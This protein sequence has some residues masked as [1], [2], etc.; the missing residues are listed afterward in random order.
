MKKRT[1]P[2]APGRFFDLGGRRMHAVIA[3]ELTGKPPI[4]LEAGLTG[5]SSCW[6]WAQEELARQTRV[7]SYDRAG[8]G[9]SSSCDAPRNAENIVSDLRRLLDVAEIQPPFVF[10]GHSLGGIFGRAYASIFPGEISAMALIDATHPE[11]MERS[12]QIR[13]SMRR[14]FWYLKATPHLAAIGAMRLIGGQTSAEFDSL[15]A[16]HKLATKEFFS[17]PRHMRASVREAS[18][19]DAAANLVRSQR[20]GDLPLLV[21]TAPVN[22]M[23]GWMELQKDLA[24]L[25]TRSRHVVIEG[26]THITMLTKKE[27]AT[28]VAEE[29]ATLL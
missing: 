13:R 29:I 18:E 20:L 25:S 22:C 3:G 9:W 17:S 11:Q 19:W 23:P 4:V 2:E 14:F 26:A 8:L 28:R 7:L 16:I 27:F 5:M 6:H 12:P 10:G 24:Q 21:M 15:P 1:A